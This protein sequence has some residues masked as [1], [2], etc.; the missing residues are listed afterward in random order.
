VR[1]LVLQLHPAVTIWYHQP[2]DAVLACGDGIAL[3][4]RYAR[5]AQ[6]AISCRGNELRGTATSWQNNVVGGG[7]AFVVELAAGRVSDATARRNARAA[8]MVA[9]P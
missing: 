9:A 4:K 2:W 8:A 1:K 7:T 3:Q 6:M 5:L